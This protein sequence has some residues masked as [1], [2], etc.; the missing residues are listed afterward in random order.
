MSAK[1]IS[2]V[3]VSIFGSVFFG[4]FLST[5]IFTEGGSSNSEVPNGIESSSSM[6]ADKTIESPSESGFDV[7]SSSSTFTETSVTPSSSTRSE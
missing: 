4:I 6:P 1:S 2:I 3:T 5:L 7:D